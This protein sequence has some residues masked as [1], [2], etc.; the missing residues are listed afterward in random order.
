M[1]TNNVYYYLKHECAWTVIITFGNINYKLI[2]VE[3]TNDFNCRHL[4]T[5]II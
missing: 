2:R 5:F 1:R 4:R 3:L